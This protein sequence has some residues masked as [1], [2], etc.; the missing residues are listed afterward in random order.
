MKIKDLLEIINNEVLLDASV[1]D[2]ELTTKS[3]ND[4]QSIYDR[5][6]FKHSI[7]HNDKIFSI[8]NKINNAYY[9]DS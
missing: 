1:L 3:I 8:V 5:G 2:Y 9:Q 6:F 7:E 4:Y